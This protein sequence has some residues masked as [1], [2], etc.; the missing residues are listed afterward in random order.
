MKL[1]KII[2]E[3]IKILHEDISTDE[4]VKDIILN[5]YDIDGFIEA[6]RLKYGNTVPLYHATT[7]ENAKIIDREGFK[8]TDG[9]N[10]KSWSREP[11]MYFQIGK[12][13]YVASNRPVLYRLD[14][15][16]D[17][18]S[19]YAYADM[20]S[21]YTEDE[22]LEKLGIENVDNFP[23]SDMLDIIRYFVWNDMK[24]DGMELLIA[25]RNEDGDIFKNLK[26]I[27]MNENI[28][29]SLITLYR[30]IGYNTGNN[31]YSPS[32]EFAM[33]FTRSGKESEIIT[34]KVDTD[35]IYRHDPL[36]RG[37]GEED[38]NFD[39]AINT[40]KGLGLNAI[41]VDEGYNQPNSVFIINPGKR[42]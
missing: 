7:E 8:L 20:D 10:Y 18:I 28:N 37:Y 36:P 27:R 35:K 41:W 15:P 17:F 9:A 33:E 39:L 24:L 23:S 32:K 14:A 40:A 42:I 29:E 16:L 30:G 2:N 38:P 21:A 13:D 19:A 26:P 12:S 22:E 31:Y 5:S 11:I 3:E 4:K 1:S 6:L 25:D 34:K